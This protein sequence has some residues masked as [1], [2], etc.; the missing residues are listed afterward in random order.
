M[1]GANMRIPSCVAILA[2]IVIGNLAFSQDLVST[3]VS[4][5]ADNQIRLVIQN[6][7]TKPITAYAY[8]ACNCLAVLRGCW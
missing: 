1:Q 3:T 7:Y 5:T 8:D 6:N 4:I 2:L